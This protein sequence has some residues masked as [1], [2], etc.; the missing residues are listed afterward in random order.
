[1]L[2]ALARNDPPGASGLHP[3]LQACLHLKAR[4]CPGSS[5]TSKPALGVLARLPVF[6][7][8]GLESQV[9]GAMYM[10]WGGGLQGCQ[11]PLFLQ[12]SCAA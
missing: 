6:L 2:R 5:T 10:G 7:Q 1:M 9:G 8:R 11:G 12:S 3:S 4:P